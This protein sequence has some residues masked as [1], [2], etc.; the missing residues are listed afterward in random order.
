MYFQELWN[1]LITH[2]DEKKGFASDLGLLFKNCSEIMS[3]LFAQL[4]LDFLGIEDKRMMQIEAFSA[5]FG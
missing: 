4:Q 2:F 3:R 1:Q 5:S